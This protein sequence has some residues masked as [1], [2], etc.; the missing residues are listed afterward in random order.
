MDPDMINC[1]ILHIHVENLIILSH[2]IQWGTGVSA[3]YG[4]KK[5]KKKHSNQIVLEYGL[6]YFKY[7]PNL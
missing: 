1:M 6:I 2:A 3:R 5:T 7:Y 4:S